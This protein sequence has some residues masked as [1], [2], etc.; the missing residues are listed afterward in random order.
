MKTYM[1][2]LDITGLNPALTKDVIQACSQFGFTP[3][4][5]QELPHSERRL[6]ALQQIRCEEVNE[7]FADRLSQAI[8]TANGEA[9]IV[10]ILA[11]LLNE[12]AVYVRDRIDYAEWWPRS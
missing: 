6:T 12:S 7:E 1:I 11:V 3:D 5:F 2:H 10:G 8:W 9:A 4:S